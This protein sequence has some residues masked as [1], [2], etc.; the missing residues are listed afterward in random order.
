MRVNALVVDLA[1]ARTR[2]RGS[3]SSASRPRCPAWAWWSAPAAPRSPSGF[4]GCA[5]APT[6]GSPSPVT[7]RRCSRACEAVVRRRKRASA[8]VETGPLVAGE[9]E[10]RA[11]QFQAFAGGTSVDLTRR[12]FEVLATARPGRR[13]RCSSARRSTRRSG[14]TRWPTATAPWTCS[15]ARCARSSRRPRR[16]GATSTRTSASATASS[17]SGRAATTASP[18]SSRPAIAPGPRRGGGPG[19]SG[20]DLALLDEGVALPVDPASSQGT[21]TVLARGRSGGHGRVLR[22]AARQQ[23]PRPLAHQS[24]SDPRSVLSPCSE[25]GEGRA[26]ATA[27]GSARGRRRPP[28]RSGR[29]APAR[30]RREGPPRRAVR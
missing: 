27:A 6:T 30:A 22:Q 23:L 12:E 1:P 16:T 7:P 3:S 28:A 25:R 4:A 13:A 20:E 26:S 24:R 14:A 8:R 29:R 21:E 17:R 15:C 10:I 11:D 19:H 2:S 5:R 9:L 18:R